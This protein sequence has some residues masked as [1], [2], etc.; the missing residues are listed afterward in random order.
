M[1][2][3]RIA[4]GTGAPLRR[5]DVR[6]EGDT[7]AAVGEV[8]PRPGE[9][10]V[11]GAGLVLA[12]GFIDAHNHSTDGLEKEPRGDHAGVAGHHHAGRRPGRQLAVADRR[13]HRSAARQSAGR[14]RGGAGRPRHHPHPGDGPR[15][16][17][18][19]AARRGRADAHARRPGDGRG[20]LR[21]VVG[22]RVRGRQLL[23]HR[24]GGR[25]GARRRRRAAASTSRTSA[26]K[27]TSRSTPSARPSPSANARKLPVQITHIKLGTVGVWGKATEV[28][29]LVEA[30]Q[31]ARRR[32]D[33]RRLSLSGLAVDAQ[34]ARPEQ[35]VRRSGQREARARRHR[36]GEE[37]AD[38]PLERL[39]AVRR[40]AAR[41][42]GAGR[43]PH[44]TSRPTSASPGTT[45]PG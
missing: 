7:I 19:G 14:Q 26:T 12:P 3:A 13:L 40:Q 30:A 4:D 6:V 5:A 9:A 2:G 23:G 39:S 32:R 16:Q 10:V 43:G 31:Q 35:A 45:T 37:R 44:A 41:R 29:A 17:A 11:D 1:T 38:H 22:A 33:R 24:G 15:L 25:D 20:R 34:G 42:D 8:T 27:P 36:R 18:P 28:V 21:A